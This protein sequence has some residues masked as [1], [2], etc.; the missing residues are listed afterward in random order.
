MG[1]IPN[2][3]SNRAHDWKSEN[4]NAKNTKIRSKL[5]AGQKQLKIG[6]PN[7]HMILNFVPTTFLAV[8]GSETI[9]LQ[10]GHM[11][12]FRIKQ[13]K[14]AYFDF[15]DCGQPLV[16]HRHQTAHFHHP[17]L[18][19]RGRLGGRFWGRCAAGVSWG[20][21]PRRTD[22]FAALPSDAGKLNWRWKWDRVGIDS[23]PMNVPCSKPECTQFTTSL[24]WE[25]CNFCNTHPYWW[26]S[27]L[28]APCLSCWTAKKKRGE[29]MV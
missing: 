12:G 21:K 13:I 27:C 25:G 7:L 14:C 11:L 20:A 10:S 1:K 18:G 17:I 2:L 26:G 5:G 6:P 22:D 8:F 4:H 16:L 29:M 3:N 9:A 15:G 28:R 23:Q 24:C 19:R